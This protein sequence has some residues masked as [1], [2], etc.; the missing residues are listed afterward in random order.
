MV[1]WFVDNVAQQRAVMHS[2]VVS[3]LAL[4]YPILTFITR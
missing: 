4:L 2:F 3:F 1:T